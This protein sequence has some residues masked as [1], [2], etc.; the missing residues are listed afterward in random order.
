[1]ILRLNKNIYLITSELK[2]NG[3]RNGENL[4]NLARNRRE[5]SAAGCENDNKLDVTI[6]VRHWFFRKQFNLP[7]SS[8]L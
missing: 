5:V 6:E 1:M 4:T 2:W 3:S 7:L 8:T